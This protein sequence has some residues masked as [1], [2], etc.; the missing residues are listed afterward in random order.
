MQEKQSFT[1]WIKLQYVFMTLRL[2][3]YMC[4]HRLVRENVPG[5][6]LIINYIADLAVG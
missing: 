2:L 4:G 6:L 1:L 5:K 3:Y